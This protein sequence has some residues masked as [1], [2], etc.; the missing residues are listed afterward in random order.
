VIIDGFEKEACVGNCLKFIDKNCR[1][2]AFEVVIEAKD[3]KPGVSKR[4]IG[5]LKVRREVQ[6]LS[7]FI[8]KLLPQILEDGRLPDLSGTFQDENE[9]L[10]SAK[11]VVDQ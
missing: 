8:L 2:A 11:D 1:G 9:I 6:Y 7:S 4:R 3:E 10:G 5:K